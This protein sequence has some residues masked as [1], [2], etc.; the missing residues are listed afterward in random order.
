[1]ESYYQG[2]LLEAVTAALKEVE[3]TYGI[4]CMAKDEPGVLVVARSGSPIV[5]GLGD[6]ETI[7]A[8]DASAIITYTR[9]ASDVHFTAL[10]AGDVIIVQIDGLACVGDDG[11][12]V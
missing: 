5:I 10:N 2:D 9:Q 4:T 12:R 8:S 7:V 3:G 11:G 6:E 1:M